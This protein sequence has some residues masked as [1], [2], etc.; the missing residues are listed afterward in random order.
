MA[1]LV[2]SRSSAAAQTA[3][4][5]ESLPLAEP[6]VSMNPQQI[7]YTGDLPSRAV[8][9]VEAVFRIYAS[10]QDGEPLW[11]ETQT[12]TI[13]ADSRYSALLGSAS[14]TGLPQTVFGD[15]QARWL[16]VSI[17]RGEELARTLLPAFPTP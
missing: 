7:R 10:Q 11:S 13:G 2:L 8:D 1:L 15:G 4:S 6:A 5:S 3:A 17:E 12:V 16:A 14:K 9:T